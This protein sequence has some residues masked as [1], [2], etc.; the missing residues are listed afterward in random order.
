MAAVS[1]RQVLHS[2]EGLAR[3]YGRV[4]EGERAAMV[5]GYINDELWIILACHLY[6]GN[7]ATGTSHKWLTHIRRFIRMV[8]QRDLRSQQLAKKVRALRQT[9]RHLK[10]SC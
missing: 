6:A 1:K 3:F 5:C 9:Q 10:A 4:I 8:G 2:C 7:I